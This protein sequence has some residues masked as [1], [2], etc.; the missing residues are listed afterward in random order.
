M[1]RYIPWVVGLVV[2]AA[3]IY[4]IIQTTRRNREIQLEGIVTDA[5]VSRIEEHESTDSDGMTTVTN[6]YYVTYQL[7]DGTPAEALLGSGKSIDF[8][9][10]KNTWDADLYVGCRV[11]IK[12]LPDK[13]EYVV[14]I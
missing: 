6:Y 9:F 10:G 11:H 3:F 14:R 8:R 5:V 12:Y 2:A 7:S 4:W 1:M 13:P